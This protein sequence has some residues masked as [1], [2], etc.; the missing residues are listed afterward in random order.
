MLAYRYTKNFAKDHI[1]FAVYV[2]FVQ[3]LANSG[4]SLLVLLWKSPQQA[5]SIFFDLPTVEQTREFVLLSFA[6]IGSVVTANH[7][8]KVMSI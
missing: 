8:L 1:A 4:L 6:F 7:A 5:R 3:C 2:L